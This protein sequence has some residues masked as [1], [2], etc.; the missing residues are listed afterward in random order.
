MSEWVSEK[1]KGQH[2]MDAQ[3]RS[4]SE[5]ACFTRGAF[6]LEEGY[7]RKDFSRV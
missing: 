4:N 2:S 6:G 5:D 3:I 1:E 7:V